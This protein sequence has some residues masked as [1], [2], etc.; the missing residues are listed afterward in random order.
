M[1]KLIQDS[2]I[3]TNSISNKNHEVS[4]NENGWV[5][6][7]SLVKCIETNKKSIC[8]FLRLKYILINGTKFGGII[9]SP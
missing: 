5:N 4:F 6:G 2:R 9:S 8:Y 1:L 7:K 3:F